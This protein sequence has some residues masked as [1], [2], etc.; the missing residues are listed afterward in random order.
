MADILVIL[1]VE[2]ATARLQTL[3]KQKSEKRRSRARPPKNCFSSFFLFSYFLFL[4]IEISFSHIISIIITSNYTSQPIT[5]IASTLGDKVSKCQEARTNTCEK[6]VNF[7]AMIDGVGNAKNL[8]L[9]E[10]NAIQDGNCTF[11]L[12]CHEVANKC[13]M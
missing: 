13:L 12:L 5:T 6:Y 11:K 10:R 9:V 7:I 8:I 2:I 4:K 1:T 3:R